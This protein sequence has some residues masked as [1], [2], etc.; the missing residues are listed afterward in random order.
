MSSSARPSTQHMSESE[1]R[2]MVSVIFP[3]ALWIKWASRGMS[4]GSISMMLIGSLMSPK[5]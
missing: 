1:A 5:P 2:E 3:S 4:A